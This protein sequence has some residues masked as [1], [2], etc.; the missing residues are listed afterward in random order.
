MIKKS[1]SL[2]L[3]SA[4]KNDAKKSADLKHCVGLL[5]I[6]DPKRSMQVKIKSCSPI[7]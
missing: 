4:M 6:S 2:N 7:L 1:L 5:N 3:K